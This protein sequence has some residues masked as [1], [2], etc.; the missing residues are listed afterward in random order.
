MSLRTNQASF[1]DLGFDG[2]HGMI[3]GI[4]TNLIYH[5]KAPRR[6]ETKIPPAPI[7]NHCVKGV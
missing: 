2:E 7:D 5:K 3:K 6:V 1:F 4:K